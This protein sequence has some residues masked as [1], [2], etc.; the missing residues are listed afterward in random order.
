MKRSKVKQTKL[1]MRAPV[2]SSNKSFFGLGE[3]GGTLF[4]VLTFVAIIVISRMF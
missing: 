2:K 3:Y 4:I 1:N